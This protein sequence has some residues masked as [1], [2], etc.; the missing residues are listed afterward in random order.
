MVSARSTR[1]SF[2]SST[3]FVARESHKSLS[4][5]GLSTTISSFLNGWGD[6]GLRLGI[7]PISASL[8]TG[9]K[10]KDILQERFYFQDARHSLYGLNPEAVGVVAE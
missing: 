4:A 3:F 7:T 10:E 6:I 5:D 2:S 8:V 9:V 1:R